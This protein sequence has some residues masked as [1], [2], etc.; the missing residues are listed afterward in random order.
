MSKV[1]YYGAE[2]RQKIADGAKKLSKA[3]AVTMG[4]H[5]RN[6]LIGKFVGAPTITKDG[7]SVAREVVLE[8]TAEELGCRIIKEVAG[9]TADVA[10]DGTTT[11]TV[12]AEAILSEGIKQFSDGENPIFFKEGVNRAAKMIREYIH[13]T[14]LEISSYAQV[15]SIAT[16]STNNDE[17]LGETIAQAFEL[18]GRVGI[19][20]AEAY[21]SSENRIKYTDGVDL[22]SGYSTPA[23]LKPGESQLILENASI[24]ICDRDV[25]HVQDF[26]SILEHAHKENK[27]LLIIARSIRQE[28]LE[29]IAS[30]R[31][32]GRLN[33][34]TVEYPMMGKN[35]K[36]WLNDLAML[37]GTNVFSE[38]DGMP[39]R[40]VQPKDLG[41][42][43]KITITKH[44]TTIIDGRKSE[45]VI[46]DRLS[47]Y[48]EALANFMPDMD[49]KDLKDRVSFLNNKAALIG[50]AYSTE[51][52]LREKGDRVEDAICAT[53]AAIES[54]ILPG[55]GVTLL[56]A[57]YAIDLSKI[58]P[59]YHKGARVLAY[60][61]KRPFFQILENGYKNEKEI[62]AIEAEILLNNDLWHGYNLSEE[63]FGN[64]L[65]MGVIDPK[66]V[67]LTALDNAI[68]VTLLLLNTEAIL[69][70]DLI[71]PSGWQP[72]AGWRPPS[73]NN[74]NHSY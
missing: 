22:K 41:F 39:L 42:A 8:D 11:A 24:L 26:I 54:G 30:N 7:V 23:L 36:E 45:S 12:L 21:A 57:S 33:A 66:K 47:F 35:N 2:A 43:K 5:G 40:S 67:T 4:P 73:Q 10:G 48:N 59:K 17:E 44:N 56:R 6:V 29:M 52:E 71:T 31:S 70:E 51:A 50:V 68:S 61:C 32:A 20:T 28:A 27:A 53:K 72:P 58:D 19:V 62:K 34:V 9:R 25:T 18:V 55:G 16:I 1:I 69:S 64:M 60:A 13:S 74:L 3:V 38:D 15:K 14:A 37:V 63:K 49:R 65:D 46:A